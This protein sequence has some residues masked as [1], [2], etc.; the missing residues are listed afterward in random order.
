M[1]YDIYQTDADFSAY[2]QIRHGAC[3]ALSI[4]CP[5]S[6]IFHLP[7]GHEEFML[8]Y[9]HELDD[10]DK[11]VDN[12]MFIGDPQNYIDDLVGKGKV[13]YYGF[14]HAEYVAA[15]GEI[16]WGCW[17]REG[18]DFN[19]FTLTDGFGHC[20]YDPWSA[21]GSASVAQGQLIGTRVAKIL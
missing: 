8:F 9:H 18:T 13:A 1:K 20:T 10:S 21:E 3:F 2:P 14:R 16:V 12:E 6:D 4:F 5:L 17:H 11:D 19:H 15:P 7:I